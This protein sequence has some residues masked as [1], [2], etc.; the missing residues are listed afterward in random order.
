M[1]KAFKIYVFGL[2][3]ILLAGVVTLL[4]LPDEWQA[5]GAVEIKAPAERVHPYVNSLKSWQQWALADLEKEDPDAEITFSGPESG[6]GAT[7][8][9][10]S[11][12]MGRGHYTITKSDPDK[13]VWYEAALGGDEVNSHGRIEYDK[14]AEGTRVTW[15]EE[16]ELPG[17]LGGL[18]AGPVND[19]MTKLHVERLKK[20]K[21]LAEG[22]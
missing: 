3:L 10:S 15:H 6:A 14:T 20:L 5:G 7:M 21:A 12:K 4:V 11:E 8:S 18:Q 16:G 17:L 22:G 1:R 19:S 2:V 9:W 13:G